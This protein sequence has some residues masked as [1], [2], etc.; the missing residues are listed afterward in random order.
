[1]KP[2]SIL[3]RWLFETLAGTFVEGTTLYITPAEVTLGSIDVPTATV[4]KTLLKVGGYS[5]TDGQVYPIASKSEIKGAY[6][7][8]DSIKVLYESTKDGT[9]P[10]SI[11]ARIL[12]VDKGYEKVDALAD[13][14]EARLANAYI[15][16]LGSSIVL[17]SRSTGY[18]AD[19][20]EF[21]CEIR[22]SVNINI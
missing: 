11:T 20:G 22:I 2:S 4:D 8:Y 15:K 14:I 12:A 3:S 6:V 7:I 18:D 1:M 19:T 17:E 21:L 13:A 16:G 10:S 9:E 5:I